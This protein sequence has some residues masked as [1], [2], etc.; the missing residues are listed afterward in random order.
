MRKKI[1]ISKVLEEFDEVLE[2]GLCNKPKCCVVENA[3]EI[4]EFI[5]QSIENILDS[6]S[7]EERG[8]KNYSNS[9]DAIMHSDYDYGYSSAMK[10]VREEIKKIKL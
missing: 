1:S 3:G 4:K 2:I 9:H 5:R 8:T 7:Y 6:I 10:E